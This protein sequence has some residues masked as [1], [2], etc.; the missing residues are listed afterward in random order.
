MRAIR[1]VL[2]AGC[3]ALI[4]SAA[5]LAQQQNVRLR[6]TISTLEGKMLSIK[7]KSGSDVSVELP[8]G[9]N[10]AATKA[11]TMS[12]VRPGMVL[13]VTTVKRSD[14]TTV[15]I[16][17]RPIPPTATQGLSPHDLAPDSVM[18][19]ATL[20]GVVAAADG[21]ELTLNYQTG[22]V[23]ALVTSNTAMSQSTPGS[24]ADLKPGETVYIMARRDDAGMLTAV[25]VQVSKD[26]ISPTQ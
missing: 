26:G 8:E 15:A 21:Q 18:T 20:E 10:V 11:F 7:T 9:V 12:D 13:G 5:A 25:R 2:T 14:G 17:V 19:N 1:T 6:G 3:I 16:D 22:T 23:K 24:R 4:C